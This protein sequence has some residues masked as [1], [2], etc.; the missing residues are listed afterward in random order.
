V[1]VERLAEMLDRFQKNDPGRG[2]GALMR[3]LLPLLDRVVVERVVWPLRSLN[4]LVLLASD[5]WRTP[6]HVVIVKPGTLGGPRSALGPVNMTKK[7][8]VPKRTQATFF[9]EIGELVFWFAGGENTIYLI[10]QELLGG[11]KVARHVLS[12]LHLARAI[13]LTRAL[14]LE[15]Y[16]KSEHQAEFDAALLEFKRC[17]EERNEL[18]HSVS[19]PEIDQDSGVEFIDVVNARKMKTIQREKPHVTRLTQR[20]RD[21]TARFLGAAL[22][23]GIFKKRSTSKVKQRV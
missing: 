6:W 8:I 11:R 10:A 18:L 16:S 1:P 14:A 5:D 20:V 13:D 9:R 4:G 15:I 22:A 7:K 3:D 12:P 23:M 17:A 19:F 21:A 2:R